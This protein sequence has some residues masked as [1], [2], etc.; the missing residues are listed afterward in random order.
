MPY[1]IDFHSV[2]SGDNSGD[3]I[4]MRY[5][6]G[7]TWRVLVIDAGFQVNGRAIVDHVR[8]VYGTAYVDQVI[9]THP[10]ADHIGGLA[11]VLEELT[12]GELWMHVPHLHA[13]SI[14]H[15]FQ[16][17]RWTVSG[18]EGALKAAYPNVTELLDS[19]TAAGTAVK[20]PFQ[21]QKIGPFTVLSPSVDMYE[22][23]L[24]QFTGTPD[25]DRAALQSLGHWLQGIGL[26]VART[27]QRIVREDLYTETLRDGGNTQAENESSVVLGGILD[28]GV[29]LLTAD[30]GLKA[31]NAAADQAAAMWLPLQDGLKVFQ[32]PH[33]GSRNNVS[34]AIL[35]RIVGPATIP[36]SRLNVNCV[37]SAGPEDETHPRQV[38]VNALVRRGLNP[39]V[40]RDGMILCPS[41]LPMRSGFV[42]AVPLGFEAQVEA[43]D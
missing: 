31:L 27:I 17:S 38:V 11:T 32:V 20:G 15:L 6:D 12:V 7:D 5:L 1:E 3:A 26:R 39:L 36:G 22:G 23:L 13:S 21:G 8:G 10:H 42:P 18:L 28:G 40:T 4:T 25:P 35:D 24:P 30:A 33:H 29:I 43:Y 19:A 37:I 41:R 2:G 14:V 34:P 16:S 9:S